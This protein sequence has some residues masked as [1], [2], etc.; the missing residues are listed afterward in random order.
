MKRLLSLA[1][2]CCGLMPVNITHIIC[3]FKDK[4]HLQRYCKAGRALEC[5]LRVFWGQIDRA[6]SITTV[7]DVIMSAM[8]SRIT[9]LTIVYSIV[10]SSADKKKISQ[11]RVTGL[12]TEDSSVTGEF[13]TQRASKA[14]N[15]SI[16]WRHHGIRQPPSMQPPGPTNDWPIVPSP[17][18]WWMK[19]YREQTDGNSYCHNPS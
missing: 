4:R 15:V 19:P 5:L 2:N 6:I 11:L 14:E 17:R 7:Y 12:C 18:L 1:E 13:P 9:S 16:W 10:Y 8:A 3:D